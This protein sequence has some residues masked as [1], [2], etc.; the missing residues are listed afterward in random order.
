MAV[1]WEMTERTY[2][3]SYWKGD[4]RRREKKAQSEYRLR[5]FLHSIIIS[6]APTIQPFCDWLWEFSN[7][8]PSEHQKT[9]FRSALRPVINLLAGYCFFVCVVA[10]YFLHWSLQAFVIV[11]T[12]MRNLYGILPLDYGEYEDAF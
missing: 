4:E 8:A 7:L 9:L 6:Y 10:G 12:E 1:K 2:I 3:V 11:Y 5:E